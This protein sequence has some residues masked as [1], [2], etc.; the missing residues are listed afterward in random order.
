ME[1]YWLAIEVDLAAKVRALPNS[2]RFM[3]LEIN[4]TQL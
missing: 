1:M 2:L 4:V 3:Y